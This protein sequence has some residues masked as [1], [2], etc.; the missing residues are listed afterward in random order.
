MI[1]VLV[2][3]RVLTLIRCPVDGAELPLDAVADIAYPDERNG[4]A[5][6]EIG[7]AD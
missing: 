6:D 5:I 7:F 2:P 3:L 4:V 1:V